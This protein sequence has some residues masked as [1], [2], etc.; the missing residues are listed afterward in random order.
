MLMFHRQDRHDIWGEKRPHRA[1]GVVYD[2]RHERWGNYVPTSLARRYDAFLFFDRTQA[3][4]PLILP[5]DS[6]EVPE[7]YPV[8]Q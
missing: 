6:K 7:T 3:L 2:P 1:I 4:Q 5:Y 8:G